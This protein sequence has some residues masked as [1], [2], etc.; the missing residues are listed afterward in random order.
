MSGLGLG[1]SLDDS[2][3]GDSLVDFLFPCDLPVGEVTLKP[4][5]HKEVVFTL[6]DV[7]EPVGMDNQVEVCI[8]LAVFRNPLQAVK[9]CSG[10]NAKEGI[11]ADIAHVGLVPREFVLNPA[12]LFDVL[13]ARAVVELFADFYPN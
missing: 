13:A 10:I 3:I 6:I 5:G 8:R 4:S 11:D 9:Q 1:A 7:P 2:A 12:V